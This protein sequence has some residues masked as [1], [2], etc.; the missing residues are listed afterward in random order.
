MGDASYDL[1][2]TRPLA[3][4]HAFA[5]ALPIEI[6]RRVTVHYA[7]V[8]AI[9]QSGDIPDLTAYRGVIF[10]SA[11]AVGLVGE[12][13]GKPAFCVGAQTCAAANAVGFEAHMAGETADALVAHLQGTRPK[14]PLV[15]LHGAHTRGDIANRLNS[16]G[17]E[18]HSAVIYT[19]N[20]VALPP[21]TI[22][23]LRESSASLVPLFSP[24]SAQLFAGQV[25]KPPQALQIIAL[26]PAVAKVLPD[27]WQVPVHVADAPNAAAMVV[28]I[29]Q[30]IAG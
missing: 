12:G 2:L 30:V 28:R 22:S 29:S 15:H 14:T 18:T 9:Q 16:A 7:P 20:E 27:D 23:I 5:A 13:S 11:S 21:E 1:V 4:S 26:S 10:S 8:L 24:R 17:L 3:R 19:Q 6:L 25:G